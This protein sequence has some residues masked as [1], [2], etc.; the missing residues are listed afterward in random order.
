MKE[1]K[2]STI[3]DSVYYDS[4]EH[5]DTMSDLSKQVDASNK[6]IADTHIF[7]R[8]RNL[9]VGIVSV[10]PDVV[11]FGIIVRGI[12]QV[13]ISRG[14][15]IG[16]NIFTD[17]LPDS[18]KRLFETNTSQPKSLH[19]E[20]LVIGSQDESMKSTNR[21]M[22]TLS[23]G[24][25]VRGYCISSIDTPRANKNIWGVIDTT[26][27]VMSDADNI[28]KLNTH[29]QSSTTQER[30]LESPRIEEMGMKSI[31]PELG[32][33]FDSSVRVNL[34][35]SVL[36]ESPNFKRLRHTSIETADIRN[37]DCISATRP[38]NY[39]GLWRSTDRDDRPGY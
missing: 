38:K 26:S 9:S 32:Q 19:S 8:V 10:E 18:D 33:K 17:I 25:N 13:V 37:L 30:N 5:A 6:P 23:D 28:K 12:T 35:N 27:N 22:S 7:D 4:G 29:V 31:F 3:N 16:K 11:G 36:S 1:E 20:T 34:A 2:L 24:R 39:N 21:I 14:A 15:S